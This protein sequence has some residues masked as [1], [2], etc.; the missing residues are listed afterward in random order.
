MTLW[1]LGCVSNSTETRTYENF[2]FEGNNLTSLFLDIEIL[3]KVLSIVKLV[4]SNVIYYLIKSSKDVN[5]SIFGVINFFFS[6]VIKRFCS[7]IEP[8]FSVK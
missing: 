7:I 6:G 2:S 5:L 8:L 3:G 4:N 1:M